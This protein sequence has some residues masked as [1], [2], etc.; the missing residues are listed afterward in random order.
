MLVVRM[1]SEIKIGTKDFELFDFY[2][3]T[4]ECFFVD[5]STEKKDNYVILPCFYLNFAQ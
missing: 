1:K 4:C 2:V 3:T 5:K